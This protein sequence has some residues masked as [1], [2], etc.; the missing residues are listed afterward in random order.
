MSRR[1]ESLWENCRTPQIPPLGQ[2]VANELGE[3]E[4]TIAEIPIPGTDLVVPLTVD[5][6]QLLGAA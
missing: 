4:V 2:E 5:V 3:G 1:R 6:G